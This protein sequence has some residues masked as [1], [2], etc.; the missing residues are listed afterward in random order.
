M[1]FD[2]N[3]NFRVILKLCLCSFNL[4]FYMFYITFPNVVICYWLILQ[5]NHA[6]KPT[7]MIQVMR[8][9][10]NRTKQICEQQQQQEKQTFKNISIFKVIPKSK[11]I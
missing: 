10:T 3:Q 11:Y 7:A 5:R 2:N 1:K 4:T 6:I 9:K 8:D